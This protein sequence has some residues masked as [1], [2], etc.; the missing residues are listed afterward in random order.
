MPETGWAAWARTVAIL[1][2]YLPVGEGTRGCSG[3]VQVAV[4]GAEAPCC[5][6]G[7][8]EAL[9]TAV[10]TCRRGQESPPREGGATVAMPALWRRAGE[11]EAGGGGAAA[12]GTGP[13]EPIVGVNP[14]LYYALQVFVARR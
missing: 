12:C 9:I 4:R 2:C 3:D 1:P 7:I 13:L 10:E 6:A 11:E 8:K 14:G 5:L